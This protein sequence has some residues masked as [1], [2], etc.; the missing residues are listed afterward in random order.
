MK[1]RRRSVQPKGLG[2]WN[3]IGKTQV[4]MVVDE[5]R[6]GSLGGLTPLELKLACFRPHQI[7]QIS[8]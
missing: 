4:Y 2:S 1:Q 7:T 6:P 3:I 8:Q 5:Q